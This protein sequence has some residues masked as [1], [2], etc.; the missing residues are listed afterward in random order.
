MLVQTHEPALVARTDIRA[1]A[2]RYLQMAPGGQVLWIADPRAATP[3]ASMREAMRMAM[4]LPASDKAYGLP[5]GPQ[6]H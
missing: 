1:A 3:F 2:E 6:P 4:R 5:R